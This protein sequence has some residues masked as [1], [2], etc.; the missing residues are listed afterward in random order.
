[1]LATDVFLATQGV[2]LLRKLPTN[3]S[4]VFNDDLQNQGHRDGK[5]G[6]KDMKIRSRF[7]WRGV[8]RGREKLREISMVR[9]I[10]M[11]YVM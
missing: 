1:M 11:I 5:I 2:F 6:Q 10:R 7:S 9:A 8:E 4:S 3:Q